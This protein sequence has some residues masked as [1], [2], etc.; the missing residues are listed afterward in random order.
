M[1][2]RIEKMFIPM[3]LGRPGKADC[4]VVAASQDGSRRAGWSVGCVWQGGSGLGE[5]VKLEGELSAV[6]LAV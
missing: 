2:D 5:P 4:P 1:Y 6:H 3:I